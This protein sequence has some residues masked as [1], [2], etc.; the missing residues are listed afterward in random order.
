MGI[1]EVGEN[2]SEWVGEIF[3]WIVDNWEVELRKMVRVVIGV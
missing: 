2:F 3:D 1:V